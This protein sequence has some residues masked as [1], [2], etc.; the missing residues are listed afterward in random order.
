MSYLADLRKI[1]GHRPLLSVGAT[2]IV[3][4]QNN[5]ILLNHRSDTKTWGIPGG[6]AEIGERIEETASRELYEE[7]GLNAESLELLTVLSGNDFYFVY[8][9]GDMLHS[10]VVLFQAKSV[11]GQLQIMDDESI[12]LGYFSFDNLPVLESRAA[13]I[14]EWYRSSL[15]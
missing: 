4:N 9:N 3:L 8:P 5:E 1:L 14:I 6:A 15:G 7:T 2:V 13:K 10:V 11:S 12:A